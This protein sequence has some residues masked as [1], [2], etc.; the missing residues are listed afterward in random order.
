MTKGDGDKIKCRLPKPNQDIFSAS[1]KLTKRNESIHERLSMSSL[2]N[3]PSTPKSVR[4]KFVLPSSLSPFMLSPAMDKRTNTNG[5][6]LSTSFHAISTPLRQGFSSE[7]L[8]FETDLNERLTN[9]PSRLLYE[10]SQSP[11]TSQLKECDVF[12]SDLDDVFF[13]EFEEE[14]SNVA[15]G[16]NGSCEVS[17]DQLRAVVWRS[18]YVNVLDLEFFESGRDV[19]I[20]SS[21]IVSNSAD[22]DF[23]GHHFDILEVYDN[24]AF[25]QVFKVAEKPSRKVYAVKRS[26][27]PFSGAS[28]RSK[29]LLEV[30]HLWLVKGSP[31][32]V[33]IEQAWE[34]NGYLFIQTDLCEN[35]R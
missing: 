34:Q 25:S 9:S 24:G 4:S 20:P 15:G 10:R 19:D 33:K 31:H 32:C 18:P 2:S 17:V 11:T 22:D 5:K 29:K 6:I 14:D 7:Q 35:G 16:S 12:G 30:H 26:R 8:V 13:T 28:D 23:F 21:S 27:S 3:T 1:G